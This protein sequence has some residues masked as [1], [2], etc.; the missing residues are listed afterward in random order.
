MENFWL[1]PECLENI[2]IISTQTCPYCEKVTMDAGAICPACKISHWQKNKTTPLDNLIVAAKYGRNNVA[3]LVHAFKYNFAEDLSRPLSDVIIKALLKN[4][5]LLPDL[6]V[7]VPLHRRRLRWRGF[8]QAE[9]LA[10]HIAQNLVPGFPLP[11]FAD[12]IRRKKFTPPQMKI[13][14][15]KERQKNIQNAFSL[16]FSSSTS[17]TSSSLNGKSILLIDDICTTGSTL[18]ECAKL[19]KES[20]A[21]KVFAAVIARQEIKVNK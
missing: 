20:G 7:P 12:L 17:L 21:K 15:Y 11:V 3:R 9:L 10:N 5:L 2:E 13:K 18:L 1:C 14:N 8:N 4:N 19:L 16:A 6:I